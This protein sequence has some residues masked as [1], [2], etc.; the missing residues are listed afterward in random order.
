MS[1]PSLPQTLR[2]K[3]KGGSPARVLY[4]YAQLAFHGLG[5]DAGLLSRGAQSGHAALHAAAEHG[6]EEVA[7]LLLL[8][9]ADVNAASA[10]RGMCSAVR[11]GCE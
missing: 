4:R 3:R 11:L 9:R 5:D 6:Q 7:K 1:A 10:V 8:S 2:A